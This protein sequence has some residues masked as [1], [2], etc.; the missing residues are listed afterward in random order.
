[1]TIEQ[2]E[3]FIANNEI[4]ADK[5][6]RFELK[7]RE[8]VRG[9]F[10]KGRDYNDLKVKN[11]W[12]IVPQSRLAAYEKSKDINLSRIFL[13]SDFQKLTFVTNKAEE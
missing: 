7:K 8:P 2:I 9:L 12:R 6:I 3:N 1:M 10:V 13:G 5:V 4:P 11:F